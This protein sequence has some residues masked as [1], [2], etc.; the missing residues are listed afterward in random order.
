M[1][2]MDLEINQS[3][4]VSHQH[5]LTGLAVTEAGITGVKTSVGGF[6]NVGI[7]AGAG[8]VACGL[9]GGLT[10]HFNADAD[11][12]LQLHT[13]GDKHGQEQDTGSAGDAGAGAAGEAEVKH[14][15]PDFR[16]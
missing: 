11:R 2:E 12:Q 8:A 10:S 7:G 5:G 16:A 14:S 15:V 3:L 4:S 9:T 6:T 1:A 13:Q